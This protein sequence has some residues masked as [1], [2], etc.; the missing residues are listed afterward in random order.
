MLNSCSKSLRVIA[1]RWPSYGVMTRIDDCD[2]PAARS[3]ST[4]SSTAAAST[5]LEKVPCSPTVSVPSQL[6]TSS[7][8]SGEGHGNPLIGTLLARSPS[9]LVSLFS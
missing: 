6:M 2:T 9:A 4:A 1:E 5:A 7:G 3:S 8:T